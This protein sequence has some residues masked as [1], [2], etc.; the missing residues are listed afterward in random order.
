MILSVSQRG[1]FSLLLAGV[2]ALAACRTKPKT[3]TEPI[4]DAP[5][6]A[7]V[8][9]GRSDQRISKPASRPPPTG[10]ATGTRSP[11]AAK[12]KPDSATKPK[13]PSRRH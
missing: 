6:E 13:P 11:D 9:A 12:L 1:Y 8:L 7:S 4:A 3:K 10:L 2:M 5:V